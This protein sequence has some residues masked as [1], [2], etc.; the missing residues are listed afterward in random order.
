MNIFKKIFNWLRGK[1]V[2]IEL[3]KVGVIVSTQPSLEA[4]INNKFN[5]EIIIYESVGVL[6]DKIRWGKIIEEIPYT[7]EEVIN[8]IKIKEIPIVERRESNKL[9]FNQGKEFGEI[10][11]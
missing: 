9:K 4:G 11:T 5:K 2:K 3:G 1:K 6:N 8:L 10:I 7:E